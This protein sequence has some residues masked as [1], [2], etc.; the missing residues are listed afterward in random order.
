VLAGVSL[1]LHRG[2]TLGL[3]GRSGAGK[4]TLA[5][6][7]AGHVEP[8]SGAIYLSGRQISPRSRATRLQLVFQDSPA[9]FNPRWTGLEV[10]DE[11][12]RLQH[13]GS[14]AA[15]RDRALELANR[16]GLP[17]AC[18]DRRPD[19]MSGGERQRLAIARAFAIQPIEVLILDEPLR[20]LDA[21][22]KDRLLDLLATIR[23]PGELAIIYISHD[24]GAVR[25]IA[26]RLIVLDQGEVVESGT[27]HA[28]LTAPKHPASRALVEAIL[29]EV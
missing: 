12:L 16:V 22:S 15:R 27:T 4:S 20:G 6:C 21:P 26:D 25:R 23:N 14:R 29:P 7:L 3:V 18:L 2:E 11:P 9:A 1:H 8:T 10:M 24:L 5:C 28:V 19:Q 13:F 17:S